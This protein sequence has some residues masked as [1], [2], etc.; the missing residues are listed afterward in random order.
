MVYTAWVECLERESFARFL[1]GVCKFA[2]VMG[3]AQGQDRPRSPGCSMDMPA[4]MERLLVPTKCWAERI[5]I[6]KVPDL[7]EHRRHSADLD[8]ASEDASKAA[9]QPSDC[10]F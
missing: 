2:S 6:N 4:S 3:A 10:R 9:E 5:G 1:M 8:D 7:R